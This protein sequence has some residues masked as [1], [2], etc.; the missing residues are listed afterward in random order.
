MEVAFC[1][2]CKNA[3]RRP[4]GTEVPGFIATAGATEYLQEPYSVC[5]C[6]ACGLLYKTRT[7]SPQEFADYY[8][9]TDFRK[10][11]TRDFY[12]TERAVLRHLRTLPRR[13]R[14]LDFG[15]SSGRLL[16]PLVYDYQCFGCEINDSAMHEALSKR[17]TMLSVEELASASSENYDAIVMLDVFEHLQYPTE[18]LRMLV[19]LLKFDGR[20]IVVTGNGDVANC[21][22]DPSQF[23]YFRIIE[24]VAMLTKDHA[25]WL[26]Q[27]LS[28]QLIEWRRL[29]HYDWIWPAAIGQRLRH[30][31]YWRLRNG[32]R[33]IRMLLRYLPGFKKAEHWPVAPTLCF[34]DDHIMAVFRK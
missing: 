27:Q 21:R 23:W 22:V 33:Q 11:E 15:C 17:I 3:H 9:N 8:D 34:S 29:S 5:E 10:W 30:F 1:P 19:R 28:L 24:H 12:P 16:S 13:A 4:T 32:T 20:L 31:A 7:L 26:E 6:S 14:I 2:A 25:K 18:C